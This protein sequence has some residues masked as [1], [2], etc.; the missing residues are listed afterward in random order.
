V[1]SL[2]TFE[3]TLRNFLTGEVRVV[4]VRAGS[5]SSARQKAPAQLCAP[6]GTDCDWLLGKTKIKKAPA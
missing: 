4:E 6:P 3:I 1:G 5:P 2:R